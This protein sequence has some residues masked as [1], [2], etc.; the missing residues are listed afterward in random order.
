[1]ADIS[2]GCMKK[3]G[4]FFKPLFTKMSALIFMLCAVSLFADNEP[5]IES[6]LL[7][8][9]T[10]QAVFE[11]PCSV[12][13][14]FALITDYANSHKVMPNVKKSVVL[15]TDRIGDDDITYVETTVGAAFFTTKYTAKMTANRARGFIGWEQIKGSFKKNSGSWHLTALSAKRTKVVYK[16]SLSH[17][18]MPSSIK[19]SLVKK[20]L[21]DLYESLK[22]H[23]AD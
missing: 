13:R 3:S 23:T 2:N 5:P 15:S 17:T 10:L 4:G 11:L 7:D 12:D 14:L 19:N 8:S 21:P 6:K 22:K 20:S 9:D 18:L 16:T 1:M